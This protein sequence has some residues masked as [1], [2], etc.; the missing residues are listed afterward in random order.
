MNISAVSMNALASCAIHKGITSEAIAMVNSN[1]QTD[2]NP[3][4]LF[5]S[6]WVTKT[7]KVVLQ[8]FLRGIETKK[9][10]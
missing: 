6:I 2:G 1:S 5:K 7:W 9:L 10:S 3:E 4:L 8:G